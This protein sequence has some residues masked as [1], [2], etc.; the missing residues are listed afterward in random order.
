[1]LR[2]TKR[3]AFCVVLALLA[4]CGAPPQESTLQGSKESPLGTKAYLFFSEGNA[5]GAI[6]VYRK[7]VVQALRCDNPFDVALYTSNIG[8]CF[9]ELAR[10]DSAL[11]YFDDA[12]E[13]FGIIG[14][15]KAASRVALNAALASARQG[16]FDNAETRLENARSLWTEKGDGSVLAA[17][18]RIRWMQSRGA[19]AAALLDNAEKALRGNKDKSGLARVLYCKAVIAHHGGDRTSAR[20]LLHQALSS[21]GP[22]ML[23]Y[24]RWPILLAL[25]ASYGCSDDGKKA[26]HFYERAS[27]SKP[28]GLAIP[29]FEQAAECGDDLVPG[30]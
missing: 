7:A 6:A 8:R 27:Y 24:D 29:S 5:E 2:T 21:G 11:G 17:E 28:D 30:M 20:Q 25:A 1:M 14:A 18:A 9:Y 12:Y 3:T 13:R 4:V 19:D 23:R 15:A 22:S 10:Y 26:R 16:D